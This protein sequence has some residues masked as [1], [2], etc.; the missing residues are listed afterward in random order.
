MYNMKTLPIIF[1]I[2]LDETLIGDS[3]PII[4]LNELHIYI[5]QNQK[6]G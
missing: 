3:T 4:K 5:L 1:F 2:D 6:N